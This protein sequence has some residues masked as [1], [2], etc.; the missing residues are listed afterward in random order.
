MKPFIYDVLYTATDE[1]YYASNRHSRYEEI[2]PAAS[3]CDLQ[4]MLQQDGWR[5]SGGCTGVIPGTK[6]WV[7]LNTYQRD[8][9]SIPPDSRVSSL[10]DI[11][12]IGEYD[13][14]V[15]PDYARRA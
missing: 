11:I 5:C 13:E 4:E 15:Y 8:R 14:T 6:I 7:P 10:D 12:A 9:Y 3:L 2:Y 1:T